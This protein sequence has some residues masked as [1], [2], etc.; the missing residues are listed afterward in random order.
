MTGEKTAV[1]KVYYKVEQ[2]AERMDERMVV[3]RD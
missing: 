1:A 2:M 3:L